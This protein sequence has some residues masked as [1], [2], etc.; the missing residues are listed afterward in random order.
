MKIFK[1]YARMKDTAGEGNEI[2]FDLILPAVDAEAATMAAGNLGYLLND[3]TNHR[4]KIKSIW[5]EEIP[6]TK[7]KESNV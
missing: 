6:G 3:S 1:V 4:L 2:V 5:A 7:E